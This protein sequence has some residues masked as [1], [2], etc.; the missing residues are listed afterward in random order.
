MDVTT[1]S[2]AELKIRELES[3][4][5][6]ELESCEHWTVIFQDKYP[7]TSIKRHFFELESIG[8]PE[9]IQSGYA[10]LES[11]EPFCAWSA[12]SYSWAN[13][14][15]SQGRTGIAKWDDEIMFA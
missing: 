9:V 3:I 2:G 4:G 10:T 11:P 1:D 14:F 15:S 12:A 5:E 8:D 7:L 13:E 6:L